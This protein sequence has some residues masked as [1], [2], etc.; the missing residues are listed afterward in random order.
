MIVGDGPKQRASDRF[1]EDQVVLDAIERTP[2]TAMALSTETKAGARI[3][4]ILAR[5]LKKGLVCCS[6]KGPAAVW[7]LGP[8]HPTKRKS[9]PPAP[10]A[11]TPPASSQAAAAPPP[12]ASMEAPAAAPAPPPAASME[13][14]APA[15]TPATPPKARRGAA[16]AVPAGPVPRP[17]SPDE[18]WTT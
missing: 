8:L 12:A 15:T 16:A 18:D 9:T 6:G 1:A 17:P 5:L 3:H 10:P 4:A 13:A 7:D 2:A 11:A 14:P